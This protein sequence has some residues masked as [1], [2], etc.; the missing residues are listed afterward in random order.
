MRLALFVL[1]FSLEV[2]VR[3]SVIQL[4]E[5]ESPIEQPEGC[6]DSEANPCAMQTGRGE[7][8]EILVGQA[9]VVVDQES[10]I[11][12][13][14]EKEIRLVAGAVWVKATKSS[15]VSVRTEFGS[16]RGTSDFWVSREKEKMIVT[17]VHRDVEI[18]PRGSGEALVVPRGLEN[19]IGRVGKNGQATVGLPTPIVPQPHLERWARLYSGKKAQFEK[20]VAEFRETWANSKDEAVVIHQALF[21]RK[22]ASIDEARRQAEISRQKVESRNRELRDLFRRKTLGIE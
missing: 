3:A 10:S 6:L 19:F 4:R 13:V 9:K 2:R 5:S 1:V 21:Q 20:E 22:I 18:F 14:S 17:A 8:L 11:I 15:P 12:R 7:K 16:T